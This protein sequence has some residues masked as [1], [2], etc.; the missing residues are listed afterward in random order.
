MWGL[1]AQT[2]WPQAL[3]QTAVTGDTDDTTFGK[4][5]IRGD[6]EDFYQSSVTIY[7]LSPDLSCSPPR[8]AISI[9]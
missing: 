5:L 4:L 2:C 1:L 8:K 7:H 6:I 9:V 3:S